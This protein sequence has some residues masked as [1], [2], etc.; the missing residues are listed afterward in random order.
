MKK[1]FSRYAPDYIAYM[2]SPEW[3]AVRQKKLKQVGYKCK[4][5]SKYCAGPLQVHHKTYKRF[6]HERMSDLDALCKFHHDIADNQR[7]RK[8]KK[9]KRL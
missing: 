2:H 4:K 6:G 8:V 7:R 1:I 5:A 3:E 9:W